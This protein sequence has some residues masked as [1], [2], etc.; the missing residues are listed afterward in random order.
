MMGSWQASPITV[1][2]KV[3]HRRVMKIIGETS[4]VK[5]S[6]KYCSSNL[7]HGSFDLYEQYPGFTNFLKP[8][9]NWASSNGRKTTFARYY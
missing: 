6:M 1:A 5:F 7:K 2:T 3:V 8:A 9:M 4:S